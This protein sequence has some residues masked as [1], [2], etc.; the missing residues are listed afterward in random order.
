NL[1]RKRKDL[2]E[3]DTKKVIAKRLR[4][5]NRDTWPVIKLLKK[6]KRIADINGEQKIMKIHKDILQ[7]LD[8]IWRSQSKLKKK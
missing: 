4:V 6:Q 7:A 1:K 2:P 3:L 8:K 5:F